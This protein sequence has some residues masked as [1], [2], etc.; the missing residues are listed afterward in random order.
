MS[1]V[2]M[3]RD[4]TEECME[5]RCGGGER[6]GNYSGKENEINESDR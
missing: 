4:G 1:W 3:G 6:Y 5:V 2:G